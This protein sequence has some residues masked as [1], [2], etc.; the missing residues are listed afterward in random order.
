MSQLQ[1]KT[2]TEQEFKGRDFTGEDLRGVTFIKCKFERCYFNN[3][4]L[5]GV[6]FEI[7]EGY[8]VTFDHADLTNCKFNRGSFLCSSFIETQIINAHL[9][10]TNF[11]ESNLSGCKFCG[12]EINSIDISKCSLNLASFENT[13]IDCITYLPVRRIPYLRKLRFFRKGQI[14]VNQININGNKFL[15]FYDFCISERRKDRFFQSA[16]NAYPLIRP[17]AIIFLILFGLLTDFGQSLSRW[18]IC[19]CGMILAYGVI[20]W[21][22]YGIAFENALYYSTRSFFTFDNLDTS[23]QLLFLSESIIGYFMLGALIS[24]LTTKLSI[25]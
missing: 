21:L 5:K 11:C 23:M 15:D 16:N 25:Q 8:Q 24:L 7:C 10:G 18:I 3:M 9:K 6:H 1:Q 20:A 17:F 14:Q 4:D 19:A 22:Q 13:K 12:S 2:I